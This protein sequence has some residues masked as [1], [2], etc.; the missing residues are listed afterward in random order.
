MAEIDKSRAVNLTPTQ[1]LQAV[2]DKES[3][4][5]NLYKRQDTDADLAK[6][7]AFTLVDDKNK[8]I[9]NCDH[10]TLPKAANFIN[11]ANAITASAN[12][13]LIIAGVK[14]VQ[15]NN[16]E[17]FYNEGFRSA[18]EALVNRNESIA[19]TFHSHMINTRG[20]IGH[21]IIVEIDEE[22][23]RLKVEII[24]WDFRYVTYEFDKFGLAWA[25][26][27]I[28]MSKTAIDAAYGEGKAR[29]KTGVVR[30]FWSRSNNFVFVDEKSVLQEANDS[31]EVPVAM[32]LS[33]AGLHFQDKDME[34]NRGESILWLSRDLY[35]EANKIISI[36]QTL[37]TGALFPPLQKE[38]EEIP[39]TQP[40]TPQGGTRTVVPY[41]K[42]DGEYKPMPRQ[43]V[44]QATRMAWS[45]VD[46]HIQQT[47]FSTS[48]MGTLQF[49]LSS[50]ALEELNEG[51]ELVLANSIQALSLMYLQ[52]SQIM[53]RQFIALEGSV[54]VT[55]KEGKEIKI[56][57]KDVEEKHDISFTYFTNSR[58]FILAGISE[59]RDI[60]NLV[61]DGYKREHLLKLE[62]P[63]AVGA[64]VEAQEAKDM[65]PE[66]K[67]YEQ[68]K[69]FVEKEQWAEAW[70]A[71]LKLRKILLAEYAPE[72]TAPAV[73]GQPQGGVPLFGGPPSRAGGGGQRPDITTEETEKAA[74]ELESEV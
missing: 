60:G 39:T 49:P 61:D 30:D 18:D 58:K 25:S 40:P 20:R 62:N 26:R 74:R 68:L 54:P 37:N 50:L 1:A 71:R 43:D 47:S 52:T 51:Q 31:G 38:Y 5:G 63:E 12:Q 10:V 70:M 21:R 59:S 34:E 44:Y 45:I 33:P 22:T 64:A 8:K 73:D 4:F 65:H 67:V 27:F 2:K 7:K 14:D 53:A 15:R 66:L 36:V 9:P 23:G 56:S 55:D 48:Q 11:R 72:E 3:T 13:Q 42:A 17:A 35:K 69:S 16:L 41:K 29:G 6:R 24:P 32:A 28:T 46:S 19:F 57:S